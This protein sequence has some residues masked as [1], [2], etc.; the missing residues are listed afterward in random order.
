MSDHVSLA[1]SVPAP[2]L[3][4]RRALRLKDQPQTRPPRWPRFLITLVVLALIWG[5]LTEFR[6]DA[7]VFG[8]P[9]VLFGAALVFLMPAVPGW[10]L[11]LPG[12]LRF[13]RFFAVQS[14]LGAIDVA[15]RAFSPRMPLRPGFRHYPLTLPAGAPRIVFLNTVT[16]LPGTLS[17]EVREDEVIVHMLDTR[18]DLA[19]SLGALETRVSDLFAVSDRS[20]ISK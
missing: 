11:S 7:I 2:L 17:A 16:L 8:L 13:A 15:L 5:I 10:R 6:L 18:A 19:A 4:E 3:A 20:E 12:A 9:A 1:E 14:V